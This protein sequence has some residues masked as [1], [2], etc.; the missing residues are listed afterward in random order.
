[1]DTCLRGY[2][3]K[4]RRYAEGKIASGIV[5]SG[6]PVLYGWFKLQSYS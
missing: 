5:L 3:E 1:M 4:I 6:M 2:D